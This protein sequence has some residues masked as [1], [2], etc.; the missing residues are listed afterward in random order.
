MCFTVRKNNNLLSTPPNNGTSYV[1]LITAKIH[2][3][4]VIL[5]DYTLTKIAWQK[6]PRS[7]DICADRSTSKTQ[8]YSIQLNEP[9][10]A[11]PYYVYLI[12]NW[13]FRVSTSHHI[14][15]QIRKS[16]F[17]PNPMKHSTQGLQQSPF[18]CSPIK[19]IGPHEN[20]P[21]INGIV[22][23]RWFD[24][25]LTCS[26]SLRRTDDLFPSIKLPVAMIYRFHYDQQLPSISLSPERIPFGTHWWKFLMCGVV[27]WRVKKE[28]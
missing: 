13:E 3:E 1:H 15:Y 6:Y 24:I 20:S 11:W 2:L 25:I 7:P 9:E 12:T 8:F 26:I 5:S 18:N 22:V 16:Y 27:L 4:I 19:S 21:R 10:P 14:S 28:W 23:S 17:Q